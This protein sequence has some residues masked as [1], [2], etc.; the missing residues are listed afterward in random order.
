MQPGEGLSKTQR[1]S[2]NTLEWRLPR[3]ERIQSGGSKHQ[4]L[5][6]QMLMATLHVHCKQ[7]L[8]KQERVCSKTTDLAAW[9]T[10][11]QTGPGQKCSRNLARVGERVW[12]KP[13][14]GTCKGGV[15]LGVSTALNCRASWSQQRWRQRRRYVDTGQTVARH[16]REVVLWDTKVRANRT[17]GQQRQAWP[18]EVPKLSLEGQELPEERGP[19]LKGS[20]LA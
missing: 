20:S 6:E 10:S 7:L 15:R 16:K 13:R 3:G 12:R 1:G 8:T 4:R 19:D 9:A 18:D 5:T 2:G 11:V 17:V 14:K